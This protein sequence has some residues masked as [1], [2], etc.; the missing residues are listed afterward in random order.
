MEIKKEERRKRNK[1]ESESTG[2]ERELKV[3]NE[4]KK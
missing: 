1:K 3:K 2:V 4:K